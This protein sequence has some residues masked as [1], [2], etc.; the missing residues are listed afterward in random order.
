M[1]NLIT[2]IVLISLF[3][4]IPYLIALYIGLQ[5]TVENPECKSDVK[6]ATNNIRVIKILNT[7]NTIIFIII[8]ISLVC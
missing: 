1:T 6:G 5:V 8:L 3:I 7:I 2:I 4:N